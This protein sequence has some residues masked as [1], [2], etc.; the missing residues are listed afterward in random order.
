MA[1]GVILASAAHAEVMAA[2]HAAAFPP[3]ERWGVEALGVLLGQPGTFGL[4]ADTDGFV[5][6]RAAADEAEILT[7]AVLPDRQRRGVASALLAAAHE[8]AAAVG[9]KA[10][11]LEVADGNLAAL[12]LYAGFGYAQV[13][14]RRRYYPGGGDALVLRADFGGLHPPYDSGR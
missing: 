1:G 2:M 10:M 13:G 12:G 6:V 8:R 3:A 9:T 4:I 14:L 5:L 11:L 7:L